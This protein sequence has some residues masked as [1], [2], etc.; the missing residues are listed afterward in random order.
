[1][2]RCRGCGVL[3]T[4][5]ECFRRR[6]DAQRRQC[7]LDPG[8]FAALPFEGHAERAEP[9]PNSQAFH[10]G[11]VFHK[12]F[13]KICCGCGQGQP[14]P[15]FPKQPCP[16]TAKD[17]SFLETNRTEAAVTTAEL[18]KLWH[19]YED[20]MN[21][22]KSHLQQFQTTIRACNIQNKL[23]ELLVGTLGLFS[24]AGEAAIAAE[25][26]EEAEAIKEAVEMLGPQIGDPGSAFFTV[27]SKLM[28]N[29]DP[30]AKLIPNET[31]QQLLEFAEVAQ[32]V[33][34]FF[35]GNVA[36]LEEQVQGCAGT[37]GLSYGTWKGANIST[38]SRRRW[39]RCPTC[40][41]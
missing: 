6:D 1:M 16:D 35:S 28:S 9:G 20:A 41:S 12:A 4:A 8:K 17:D 40:R 10:S 36:Q 18:A 27:V 34:N 24:P 29:E 22:A 33:S 31:V 21:Q 38:T 14:P 2:H 19:S 13:W 39:R 25:G 32:Q 5:D 26:V 23:T 7:A 11:P 30:T 15:D 37:I 3:H